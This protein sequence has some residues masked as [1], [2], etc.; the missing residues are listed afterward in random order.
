LQNIIEFNKFSLRF[1]CKKLQEKWRNN[2]QDQ[3]RDFYED[4]G[5]YS[6]YMYNLKSY[7]LHNY[8]RKSSMSQRTVITIP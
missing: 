1:D 6:M 3:F 5:S 7:I 2:D 8:A 4:I